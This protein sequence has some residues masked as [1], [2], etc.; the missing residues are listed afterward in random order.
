MKLSQLKIPALWI[1][2]FIVLLGINALVEL[3]ILPGFGLHDTPGN[4]LYFQLWWLVTGIWFICGNSILMA[5]AQSRKSG[6]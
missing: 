5:L 6:A 1:S 2:G 4:D 3:V